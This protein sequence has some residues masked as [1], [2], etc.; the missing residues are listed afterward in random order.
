MLGELDLERKDLENERLP[1]MDNKVVRSRPP[2]KL[3]NL[4]KSQ[5]L[6]NYDKT[7]DQRSIY[8]ITLS[9]TLSKGRCLGES[10]R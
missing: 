6:K 1:E 7:P 5:K 8:P 9:P 2:L 4:V 10:L 3:L